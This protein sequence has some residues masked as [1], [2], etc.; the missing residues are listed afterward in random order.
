MYISGGNI[1]IN[2]TAVA[3]KGIKCEGDMFISGD[4]VINVMT[5]G[6]GTWDEDDLETKAACG[7]SFTEIHWEAAA[8]NGTRSAT[9]II[10]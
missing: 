2:S 4:P 1:T 9:T 5:T 10:R 8:R 3:T 7:I 6:N